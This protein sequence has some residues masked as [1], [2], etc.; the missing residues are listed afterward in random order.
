MISLYILKQNEA[1]VCTYRDA[2]LRLGEW[3]RM[4]PDAQRR[5]NSPVRAQSNTDIS[6]RTL[7]IDTGNC[8]RFA[9]LC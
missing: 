6:T 7:S 2:A 4:T 9:V 3:P 5:G 8:S 1:F